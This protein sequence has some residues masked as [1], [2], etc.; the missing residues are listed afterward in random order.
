MVSEVRRGVRP[1]LVGLFPGLQP[2]DEWANVG[3]VISRAL[4]TGQPVY[5]IKQ[6]PGLSVKF[7]QEGPLVP[8]AGS[9]PS[10]RGGSAS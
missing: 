8:A 1:D 2:G 3:Q 9:A 5:A 7:A 10:P 4:R 6:M